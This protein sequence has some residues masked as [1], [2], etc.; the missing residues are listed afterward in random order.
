MRRPAPSSRTRH[1][2]EASIMDD[3]IERA[4]DAKKGSPFLTTDQAARY[5]GLSRQAL[6]KMR[7]RGVG[8]R[9]RKHGRYVRYHIA[10]LDAW[11][12][13]RGRISTTESDRDVPIAPEREDDPDA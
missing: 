12:E 7:R 1:H 5:V 2:D 8:P 3:D 13:S 6:E 9:Y 10:D 4:A 11:S